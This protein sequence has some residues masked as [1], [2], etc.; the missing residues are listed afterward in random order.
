MGVRYIPKEQNLYSLGVQG[1]QLFTICFDFLSSMTK[2]YSHDEV[3]E[4]L[5]LAIARQSAAGEL[6]RQQLLEIGDEL[7]LTEQD[8]Q[9]AEDEWRSLDN[10]AKDRKV[11][12]HYRRLQFRQH[13][14]KYLIVNGFFFPL[15]YFLAGGWTFPWSWFVAI[16]WGMLLTLDGWS[17]MQIEGLSFERRYQKWRRKRLLSR[18]VSQFFGR[19]FKPT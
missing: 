8:I 5:H 12:C 15:N 16:I 1:Y 14:I 2:F 10:E 3:Q 9:R 6:S 13:V 19:W 18:S 17:A 4:I 7:G 11:F